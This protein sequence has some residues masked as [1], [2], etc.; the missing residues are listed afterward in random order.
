[1]IMGAFYCLWK[2]K[3]HSIFVRVGML[4]GMCPF[5]EKR[6]IK[7]RNRVETDGTGNRGNP[8]WKEIEGD[9]LVEN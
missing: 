2:S 6:R 9:E 8:Q 3:S 7:N 5:S 1:M 4:E